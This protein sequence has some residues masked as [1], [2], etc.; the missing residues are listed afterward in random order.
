[1][2]VG[3][4]CLITIYLGVASESVEEAE[5][6]RTVDAGRDG[7]AVFFFVD[8]F[9]TV[10]RAVVAPSA[11]NVIR[12]DSGEECFV[13]SRESKALKIRFIAGWYR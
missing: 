7:V 13:R 3:S 10:V 6:W 8:V 2:M 9:A 5:E 11:G 1:M 12:F 4:N